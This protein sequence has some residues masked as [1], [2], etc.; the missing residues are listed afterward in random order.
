MKQ[1]EDRERREAKEWKKS[2]KVI[3]SMKDLIFKEWPDWPIY[4]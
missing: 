3:L 1:Q 2:D 4:H